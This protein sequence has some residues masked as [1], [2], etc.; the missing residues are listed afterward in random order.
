MI[1]YF[2]ERE[3]KEN[4]KKEFEWKKNLQGV[5]VTFKKKVKMWAQKKKIIL[6]SE[7]VSKARGMP[8]LYDS[9]STSACHLNT[10]VYFE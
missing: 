5:W 10:T 4:A 6:I 9:Q 8:S 1:Q 7:S 2:R 3:K